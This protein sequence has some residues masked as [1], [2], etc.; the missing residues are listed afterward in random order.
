MFHTHAIIKL[1]TLPRLSLLDK[2]LFFELCDYCLSS[3]QL[4]HIRFTY[5]VFIVCLS[6][7][8][9]LG[10]TPKGAGQLLYVVIV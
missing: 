6:L 1:L 10:H 2:T 5:L 8:L 4:C 3:G 7:S 9:F